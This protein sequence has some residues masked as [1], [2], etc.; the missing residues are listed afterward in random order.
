M[1]SICINIVSEIYVLTLY[2]VKACNNVL[3]Y[4]YIYDIIKMYNYSIL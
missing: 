1:L 3:H 2:F 4:K